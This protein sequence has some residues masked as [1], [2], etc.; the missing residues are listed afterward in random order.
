MVP[1]SDHQ[2]RVEFVRVKGNTTSSHVKG[3]K[4][5]PYGELE[6]FTVGTKS[7]SKIFLEADLIKMDVE[8]LEADLLES[9]TSLSNS[10]CDIILEVGTPGNAER[11]FQHCLK[12]GLNI[13]SQK[14]NWQ[15][16]SDSSQVP[17][18]YKEGSVFLSR[19]D[20]MPWGGIESFA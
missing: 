10:K 3:A 16:V 15:K 17:I 14:I 4:E 1:N 19:A 5:F 2:P 9:M 8:G 6:V 7:F 20:Q 13:F 11:I 12:L 18:S